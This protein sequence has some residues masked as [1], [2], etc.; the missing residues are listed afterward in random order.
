MKEYKI[1]GNKFSDFNGF[2]TEFDENVFGGL[3]WDGNLDAF[4]DMLRGDCGTPGPDENF[5]LTWVNSRKS[6]DALGHRE[7][8]AWLRSRY[9]KVHPDN[10]R[11]LDVQISLA[12]INNG[13]TLFQIIVDIILVHKNIELR[14]M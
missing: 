12:E 2:V 4:N 14:L 11:I 1:D 5:I 8:L 10:R 7:T 6:V 13:E 9:N 3:G